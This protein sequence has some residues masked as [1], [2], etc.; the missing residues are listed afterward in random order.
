MSHYSTLE[1]YIEVLK[2]ELDIFKET[3][4]F[5]NWLDQKQAEIS[6]D[7][8]NYLTEGDKVRITFGAVYNRNYSRVIAEDL[9]AL[10]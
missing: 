5:K 1:G 3:Q 10:C 4:L 8:V 9:T 6:H 7:N 2:S